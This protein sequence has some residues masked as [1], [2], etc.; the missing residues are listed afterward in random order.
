[1]GIPVK[2]TVT[3][4][5]THH[6]IRLT[7]LCQTNPFVPQNNWNADVCDNNYQVSYS[8]LSYLGI[9]GMKKKKKEKRLPEDLKDNA[10][11]STAII[12]LLLKWNY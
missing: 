12:I 4:I 6:K 3:K 7:L 5:D 8:Y 9:L 11:Q 10:C 2:V 1:M